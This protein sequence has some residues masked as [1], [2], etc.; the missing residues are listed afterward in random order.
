MLSY[1]F[2]MKSQ[3]IT[4]LHC[5]IQNRTAIYSYLGSS[6]VGY[7]NNGGGYHETHVK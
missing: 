7:T 2:K 1:A 3:F 4:L 5:Y 6:G